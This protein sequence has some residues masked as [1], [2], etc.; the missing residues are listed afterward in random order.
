MKNVIYIAD[1]RVFLYDFHQEKAWLRWLSS[2]SNGMR[3]NKEL[4]LAM[5]RKIA[6]SESKE[7]YLKNVGELKSSDLW[8]NEKAKPFRDWIEKTW[9]S[10]Y[11]VSSE[12]LY[13]C[14]QTL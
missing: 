1:F 3:D 7:D 6:S 11:T 10:A 12:F 5:L 2:A 4:V 14:H 13:Q 9:L 8:N